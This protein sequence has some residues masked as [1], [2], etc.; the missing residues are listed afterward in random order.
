[1]SEEK[2]LFEKLYEAGEEGFSRVVKEAL[3]HPTVS[4]AMKQALRNASVTKGKVDRS[5]DILLTLFNLP[6]KGDYNKL[7]A[8]IETVQGSLVNLSIKL[9]RLIA[10][11]EKSRKAPRRKRKDEQ[12]S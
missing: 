8:K 7:L 11:R 12:P 9:D 10:E 2:T 4:A 6:S 1:M 5:V 3:S